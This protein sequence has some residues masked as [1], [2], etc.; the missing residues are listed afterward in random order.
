M[1]LDI[2]INGGGGSIRDD[3]DDSYIKNN[4]GE[5]HAST[6]SG[7]VNTEGKVQVDGSIKGSGHI[8]KN[9]LAKDSLSAVDGETVEGRHHGGPHTNSKAP[10][11]PDGGPTPPPEGKVSSFFTGAS[12]A[13]FAVIASVMDDIKRLTQQINATETKFQNTNNMEAR[14]S[15]K[16][17]REQGYEAA[18]DKETSGLMSAGISALS[19]GFQVSIAGR[20]A[21]NLNSTQAAAKGGP[22]GAIDPATNQ[23]AV[24]PGDPHAWDSG[25]MKSENLSTQSQ[26]AGTL[27]SGATS[28]TQGVYE[29]SSMEH[30]AD[31]ALTN[32]GAQA[33]GKGSDAAAQEKKESDD[34]GTKALD[35]L[36]DAARKAREAA[37]QIVKG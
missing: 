1:L 16:L 6:V 5:D 4:E 33:Y 25:R 17:A 13:F 24:A 2:G 3:Y 22:T 26:I 34:S 30:S 20:Q 9:T 15:A 21:S 7:S 8:D 14:D 12:I 10:T 29:A 36:A 23:P 11:L 32:D 35:A 28:G 18:D 27:G 37:A 19:A 31:Q